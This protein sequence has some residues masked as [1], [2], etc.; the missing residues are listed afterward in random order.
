MPATCITEYSSGI[1]GTIEIPFRG[2]EVFESLT[3]LSSQLEMR[4]EVVLFK[5]AA[6]FSQT[7]WRE[8]VF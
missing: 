8:R 2:L 4:S 7:E 5:G 3:F 1:G 6:A